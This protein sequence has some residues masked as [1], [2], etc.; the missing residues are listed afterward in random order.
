MVVKLPALWTGTGFILLVCSSS[1]I[2][3]ACNM[4]YSI[5]AGNL[6]KKMKEKIRG[7]RGRKKKRRIHLPRRTNFLSL[8]GMKIKRII[9]EYKK[10]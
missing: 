9:N 8:I 5:S 2:Y 10:D 6:D 4:G 7:G 3:S 1:V